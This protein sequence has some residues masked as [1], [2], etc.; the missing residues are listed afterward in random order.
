MILGEGNPDSNRI[1]N[2][3]MKEFGLER[4]ID[5]DEFLSVAFVAIDPLMDG[6][7]QNTFVKAGPGFV[8]SLPMPPPRGIV[9]DNGINSTIDKKLNIPAEPIYP[10]IFI[11]A[12]S[13]FRYQID[14]PFGE[15]E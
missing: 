3:D 12:L 13:A 11:D 4:K 2:I 7:V 5:T 9:I 14:T 15:I 8:S 10:D 6:N 1:L